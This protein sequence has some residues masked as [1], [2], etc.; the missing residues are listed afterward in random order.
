MTHSK[1]R[2][3]AK[4]HGGC[5]TRSCTMRVRAKAMGRE[6]R[7]LTP[8]RCSFGRS[9]IPCYIVQCES[10]GDWDAYNPSGAAG[11]YQLMALH[12]RPWPADTAAKRLAHHRIAARLWNG[13]RGAS[14]WTCA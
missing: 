9:S 12:G 2:E 8:Y 13:G 5:W 4:T 3:Y 7:R 1:N 10:H 14:N 11:R 6:L